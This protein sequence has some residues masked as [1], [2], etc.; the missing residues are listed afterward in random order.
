[1]E[2]K[3]KNLTSVFWKANAKMHLV[4][5]FLKE[6]FFIEKENNGGGCKVLVITDTVEQVKTFMHSVLLGIKDENVE[7]YYMKNVTVEHSKQGHRSDIYL[8]RPS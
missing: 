4:H 5:F 2:L 3:E 8:G 1:M 7:D 6:V